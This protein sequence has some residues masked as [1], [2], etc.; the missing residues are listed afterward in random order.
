MVCSGALFCWGEAQAMLSGSV[1]AMKWWTWSAKVF[2]L[3]TK[4]LPAN[5]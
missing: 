3:M 5:N 1:V 2:G 4:G